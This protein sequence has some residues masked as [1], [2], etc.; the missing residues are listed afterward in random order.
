MCVRGQSPFLELGYEPSSA[1]KRALTPNFLN[2][3][4]PSVIKHT[5]RQGGIGEPL[6]ARQFPVS[7]TFEHIVTTLRQ[8]QRRRRVVGAGMF[9]GFLHN[10]SG[11]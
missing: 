3:L 7:Y 4:F 11:Y 8:E 9:A 6:A 1:Q 2:Y 5:W 10:H